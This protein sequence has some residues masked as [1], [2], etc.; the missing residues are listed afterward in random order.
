MLQSSLKSAAFLILEAHAHDDQEEF[1]LKVRLAAGH[2]PGLR[3][4]SPS[5]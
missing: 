3:W 1:P 2:R 5:G 4:L